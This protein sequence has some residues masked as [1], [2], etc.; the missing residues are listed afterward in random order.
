MKEA[1]TKPFEQIRQAQADYYS[2]LLRLHGQGVDA[3]A[4]GKQIYKD[5]RFERISRVFGDDS[6]LTVHEIGC[7]LGHY[8]EFLKSRFP[9]RKIV[10]SGSEVTP[11]FVSAC[12]AKFPDCAFFLRDLASEPCD[13][14]YDYIVLPGV[15][16]HSAGGD[17]ATFFEYCKTL[18]RQA[19]SMS[20]R[21]IA[22]NFI[23]G[24]SDYFR[25]DLFYCDVGSLLAFVAQE[26]SRFFV[27][28]HAY[29]LYEFTLSVYA[30]GHI[31]SRHREGEFARYF[32]SG[33]ERHES[34]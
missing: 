30:A 34:P 21:G 17:A 5:L 10:Y 22:V 15:F 11:D 13:E 29:P 26:L 8:H 19:F 4:S 24:F 9:D 23:T 12:R 3:V 16:Y 7:G 28:D 27:L 6:E 1:T 20:R 2:D 31:A 32:R 18:L 14:T 33:V 25:D